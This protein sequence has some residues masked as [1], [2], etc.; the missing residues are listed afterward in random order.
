MYYNEYRSNENYLF[1]NLKLI[2]EELK[3]EEVNYDD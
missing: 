1:K 2:T 3:R